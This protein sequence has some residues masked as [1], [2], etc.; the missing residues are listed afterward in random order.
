MKTNLVIELLTQNSQESDI[1]PS[2]YAVQVAEFT[3]KSEVCPDYVNGDLYTNLSDLV[4]LR[5]E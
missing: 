5:L 1:P 3:Y 4:F 2:H